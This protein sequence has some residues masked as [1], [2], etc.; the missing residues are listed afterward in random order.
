MREF[1]RR[2]SSRGGGELLEREKTEDRNGG[3]SGSIRA[4]NFGQDKREI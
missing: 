4:T 2:R 1:E 3:E